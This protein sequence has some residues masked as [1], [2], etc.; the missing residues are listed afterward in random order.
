MHGCKCKKGCSS[1]RCGCKKKLSY[2]GPGCYCINCTNIGSNTQIIES[3][4][5]ESDSDSD[6]NLE[7]ELITDTDFIYD[8][9]M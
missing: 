3:E 5:S 6:D 9:F 8:D 4:S 1:S 2:C 7:V